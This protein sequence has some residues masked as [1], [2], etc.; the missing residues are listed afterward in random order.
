MQLLQWSGIKCYHRAWW[1]FYQETLNGGQQFTCN[2]LPS[3]VNIYGANVD[4]RFGTKQQGTFSPTSI[5]H[6]LVLEKLISDNATENTVFLFLTE[7]TAYAFFSIMVQDKKETKF[8]LV[9]CDESQTINLFEKFTD[10]DSLVNKCCN[11]VSHKLK[12]DEIEYNIRFLSCL[13]QLTT[14]ERQNITQKS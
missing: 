5:S 3:T 8:F 7:A 11:I 14:S 13:C 4:V 6:Q 2:K 1:I 9:A 10:S 12:S